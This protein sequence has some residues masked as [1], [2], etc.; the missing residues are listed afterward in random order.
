MKCPRCRCPDSEFGI[1]H[2]CWMDDAKPCLGCGSQ[3][4][5]VLV[6]ARDERGYLSEV[7]PCACGRHKGIA[8]SQQQAKEAVQ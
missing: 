2:V 4:R 7:H 5:V 1:G 6:I 3:A 8:K